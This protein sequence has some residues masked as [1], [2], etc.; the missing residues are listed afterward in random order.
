[1]VF[2]SWACSQ[3]INSVPSGDKMHID[4]LQALDFRG[5]GAVTWDFCFCPLG[6]SV[7]TKQGHVNEWEIGEAGVRAVLLALPNWEGLPGDL[8]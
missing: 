2:P 4:H 6:L 5:W 1:M 8:V 3:L 7:A